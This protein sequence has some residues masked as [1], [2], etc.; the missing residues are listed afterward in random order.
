MLLLLLI[1]PRKHSNPE[2]ATARLFEV[3]HFLWLKFFN[4]ECNFSFFPYFTFKNI[5]CEF[6]FFHLLAICQERRIISKQNFN[7]YLRTF[8]LAPTQ[9]C[10]PLC[11]Y[12]KT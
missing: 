11:F 5:L 1:M 10:D 12:P 8:R 4:A 7:A 9:F 3:E 2:Y 6:A